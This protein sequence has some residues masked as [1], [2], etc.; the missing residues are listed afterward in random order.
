MSRVHPKPAAL[1]RVNSTALLTCCLTDLARFTLPKAPA[2][3]LLLGVA[4]EHSAQEIPSWVARTHASMSTQQ[5][6]H[7]C[8]HTSTASFVRPL[9]ASTINDC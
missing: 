2:R 1:A 8:T 3:A 4:Q 5:L 6:A 7:P 9:Q